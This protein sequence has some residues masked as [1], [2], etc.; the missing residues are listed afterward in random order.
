MLSRNQYGDEDGMGMMRA[1]V[2]SQLRTSWPK[3]KGDGLGGECGVEGQ[4]EA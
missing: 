2:M 3:A 4:S 1:S